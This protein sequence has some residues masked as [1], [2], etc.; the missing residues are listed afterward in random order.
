M[1]DLY[2]ALDDSVIM[3]K[4]ICNLPIEYDNLM[5]TWD[6]ARGSMKA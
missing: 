2:R 6:C 4:I 1:K 3:T 5:T